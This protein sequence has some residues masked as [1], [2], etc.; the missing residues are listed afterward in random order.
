MLFAKKSVEFTVYDIAKQIKISRKHAYNKIE[1]LR[2]L[3][4]LFKIETGKKGRLS[5]FLLVFVIFV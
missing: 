4:L 1:Q 2:Q 5:E 3:N